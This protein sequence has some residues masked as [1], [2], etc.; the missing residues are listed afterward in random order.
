MN[1]QRRK[2][3]DKVVEYLNTADQSLA[4]ALND[5]EGLRDEEQEAAEAVAETI[6]NSERVEIME[7]AVNSLEDAI[8]IIEG[9]SDSIDEAV[10][11]IVEAKG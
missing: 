3:L 7:A 6:P 5:L 9:L 1:K 11:A 8:S 2:E 10:A 4:D